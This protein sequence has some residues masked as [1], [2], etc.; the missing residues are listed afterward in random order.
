MRFNYWIEKTAFDSEWEKLKKEYREAGM[1]EET[2]NEIYKFDFDSFKRQ[3]VDAKHEQKYDG[4]ITPWGKEATDE[5]NPLLG[6][7]FSNFSYMDNYS[8]REKRF[9]W[10]DSITNYEL[11]E[12]LLTLSDE[13]K[14]LLTLLINGYSK[15]EI[16]KQWN[17]SRSAISDRIRII[18]K[19]LEGLNF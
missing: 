5:T 17:V 15:A 18:K 6:K 9:A 16:A 1:S 4:F 12:K 11:Y 13:N 8:L 7:Y 2:I 3:R 19:K 10:I 14:E